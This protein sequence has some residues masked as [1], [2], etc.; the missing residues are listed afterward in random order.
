MLQDVL[1]RCKTFHLV[2]RDKP[3]TQVEVQLSPS[4]LLGEVQ[5]QSGLSVSRATLYRWRQQ[6]NMPDPPYMFGHVLA[7]SRYGSYLRLGLDPKKAKQ[8]TI[9]FMEAQGL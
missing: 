3:M 6:L 1:Q 8:Q 2:S 9:Q 5:R 4:A 7:L